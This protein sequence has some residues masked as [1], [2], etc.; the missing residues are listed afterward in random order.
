MT[1][2]RIIEEEKGSLVGEKSVSPFLDLF[3]VYLANGGHMSHQ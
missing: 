2:I 1:S 3:F